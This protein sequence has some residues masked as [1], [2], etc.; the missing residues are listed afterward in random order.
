MVT[1]AL[2]GRGSNAG[3]REMELMT[4][5]RDMKKKIMQQ[6]RRHGRIGVATK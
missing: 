3:G 1:F 6:E 2:P 4:S 5:T